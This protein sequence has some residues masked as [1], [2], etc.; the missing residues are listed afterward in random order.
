LQSDQR[1]YSGSLAAFAL[2]TKLPSNDQDRR[3]D[4]NY[5]DD[6]LTPQG[7]LVPG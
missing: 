2:A 6:F 7:S 4:E 5:V 3:N 1:T